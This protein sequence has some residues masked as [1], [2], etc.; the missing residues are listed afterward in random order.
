[1]KSDSTIG[2]LLVSRKVP[3]AFKIIDFPESFL[4]TIDENPD[5]GISCFSFMPL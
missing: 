3:M 4:P 5:N 2:K 1:L